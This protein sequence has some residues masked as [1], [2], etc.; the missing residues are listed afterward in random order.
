M[1]IAPASLGP[2]Q[3]MDPILLYTGT[4]LGKIAQFPQPC[5]LQGT[6]GEVQICQTR[7]KVATETLSYQEGSFSLQLILTAVPPDCLS[8]CF[9]ECVNASY[10]HTSHKLANMYH[11]SLSI[12]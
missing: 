4:V 5:V 10:S 11:I 3:C 7:Q 2:V 8:M 6:K 9:A 1:L 12:I